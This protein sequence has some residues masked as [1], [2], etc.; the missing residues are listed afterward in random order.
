MINKHIAV[1][2]TVHNRKEKTLKC[3]ESL[4]KQQA[5]EHYIIDI[6]LTD[7]GCTD[8]T[9]ESI[10]EL[11]PK[12]N[13]IK[14]DGN[15]F[16][17]K[18]MW[19]AWKA[20]ESEKE[21]DYICWLNDDVVLFEYALK[22]ILDC[23]EEKDNK[24]I[25][26]GIMCDPDDYSKTTYS[27]RFKKELR[28]ENGHMQEIENLH[29]NFVLIPQYV[30]QNIGIIDNFYS[31][32]GGDTD[33]SKTAIKKGL[34]VFSSKKKCGTCKKD[35]IKPKCFL[36]ETPLV[37]RFKILYTPFSYSMPRDIFHFDCKHNNI[38]I[39]LLH[40]ISIHFK[41]LFPQF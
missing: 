22:H 13:I 20:A 28:I 11:F 15:L 34:K 2:M 6:Y 16:W 1:I 10:A 30:Y 31:H 17:T 39:G 35:V 18:G 14:G 4:S 37:D 5:L 9:P 24:A 21:Y 26:S 8:G 27:G 29:G 12:V 36:K 7:D 19:T 32:S 25:I 3:L 38:F 41:C 33:Y 40:L 23:S